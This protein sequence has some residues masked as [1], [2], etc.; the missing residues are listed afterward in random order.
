MM[1]GISPTTEPIMGS[2]NL[3]MKTPEKKNL[4]KNIFLFN[5]S[6]I[7]SKQQMRGDLLQ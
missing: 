7:F 4:T 1:I 6:N 2:K 3:C 5:F